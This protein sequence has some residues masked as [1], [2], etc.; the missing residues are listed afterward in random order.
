MG[1]QDFAARPPGWPRYVMARALKAVGAGEGA[2][3]EVDQA[4]R[5]RPTGAEYRLLRA[6][7][8]A[9]AGRSK[10][11]LTE[12]KAAMALRPPDLHALLDLGMKLEWA[13]AGEL[14]RALAMM[15]PRPVGALARLGQA[16]EAEGDRA[17]AIVRYRQAL[18]EDPADGATRFRLG[19]ALARSGQFAEGLR[20][21]ERARETGGQSG[22]FFAALGDALAGLRRPAE[23]AEAYRAALIESVENVGLRVKLGKALAAAGRPREAA[24]RFREALALDGENAEAWEGLK[25]LGQRS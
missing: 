22:D 3:R 2:L 18:E 17:A 7:I 16:L 14:F 4:I 12:I 15:Q 13:E 10:E 24:R 9:E 6:E 8:L 1:D 23:A 25:Q 20:E 21:L 5:D 11:A 19:R